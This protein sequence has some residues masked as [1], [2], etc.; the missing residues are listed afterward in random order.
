MKSLPERFGNLL[1]ELRKE[2]KLSQS[3]LGI[4]C[5]LDRTF[6]SLLERGER[7]PTSPPSSKSP[8]ALGVSPSSIIKELEK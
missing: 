4:D 6:I 3:Q 1:V 8:K 5:D 2:K 7:Q